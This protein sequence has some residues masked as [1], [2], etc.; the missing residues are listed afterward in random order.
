MTDIPLVIDSSVYISTF[1]IPDSFTKTSRIFFA[2]ISKTTT[3]VLPTL[4]AAE[5]MTILARQNKATA[6]KAYQ[7]FSHFRL[8]PLDRQFLEALIENLP[9][10]H[11]KTSDLII[12]F[13]AKLYE[14]TLITWDQPL[15]THAPSLCRVLTPQEYLT[16]S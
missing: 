6:Q 15:H 10:P 8:I 2:K 12:A 4:V 14:G 5:T 16:S 9:Q 7:Y 3:I 13:T 1:G 11:L